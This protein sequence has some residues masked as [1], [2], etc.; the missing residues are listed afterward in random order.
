MAEEEGSQ[1]EQVI[2]GI[3]VTVD[4]ERAKR[5]VEEVRDTSQFF[6]RDVRLHFGLNTMRFAG[7]VAGMLFAVI[8][9]VPVM[10]Y[11]L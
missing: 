10:L 11:L 8:F 9:V 6:G 1:Y 2:L 4:D 3:P 5:A 7:L